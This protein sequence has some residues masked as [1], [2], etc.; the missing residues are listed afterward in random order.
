[1]N[2]HFLLDQIPTK[3]EKNVE[4]SREITLRQK[5]TNI[6]TMLVIVAN[7]KKTRK[8]KKRPHPSPVSDF[9]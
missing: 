2:T 4:K 1:M 9:F 5:Y 7:F 3:I 8:Q 6:E